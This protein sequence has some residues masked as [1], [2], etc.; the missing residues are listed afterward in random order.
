MSTCVRR[1]LIAAMVGVLCVAGFV[2]SRY[3]HTST[4]RP[5]DAFSGEVAQAASSHD[6]DGDGV[7]DGEDILAGA[8]AYIDTR[9]KYG[10]R[11]Y[12]GGWPDDGYGVCTDVVAQGLRSAGYDLQVLVAEDVAAAPDAYGIETPDPN[13]DF[14]RVRNQ[15]MWFERHATSLTVDTSEIAAWQAGDIVVFREH[16]GVVSDR[17]TSD[18]VPYIIHHEGPWQGAYEEDVLHHRTDVL[19]HYRVSA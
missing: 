1:V 8:L 10:S 7:A 13:I 6:E 3:Q 9:P 17:R 19:G 15:Q 14:R 2:A 5:A 4:R 12:V 16:V 18:G 11:Y